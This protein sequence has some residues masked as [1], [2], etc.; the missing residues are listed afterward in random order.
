MDHHK[1]GI[2]PYQVPSYDS[3][4]K[5]LFSVERKFAKYQFG[6]VVFILRWCCYT[7]LVVPLDGTNL[8][9]LAECGILWEPVPEDCAIFVWEVIE[10]ITRAS[11]GTTLNSDFNKWYQSLSRFANIL[12][13][14]FDEILITVH[15]KLFGSF[16]IR[17][18][19]KDCLYL[20][21]LWLPRILHCKSN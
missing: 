21:I 4:E 20:L 11:L 10:L 9:A 12:D 14:R 18:Q 16:L 5:W 15:I 8:E 6:P 1:I 17:R 2:V 7:R 13:V 3:E 19:M